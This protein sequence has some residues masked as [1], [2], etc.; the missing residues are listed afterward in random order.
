MGGR[1][2]QAKAPILVSDG[3]GKGAAPRHDEQGVTLGAF[4][5]LLAKRRQVRP[6]AQA[7]AHLDHRFYHPLSLR[8]CWSSR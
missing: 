6:P 5:E 8:R 4:S 7:T 3:V 2:P 1:G